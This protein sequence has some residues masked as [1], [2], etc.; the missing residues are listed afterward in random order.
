MAKETRKF[1]IGTL[2][3]IA[4]CGEQRRRVFKIELRVRAK[5]F[6]EFFVVAWE[7]GG[8]HD[9]VHF[10]ANAF[11]FAE[12]DLVN[13]L[14]S[15][16][17]CGVPFHVIQILR[18]AIRQRCRVSGFTALGQITRGQKVMQLLERRPD[19]LLVRSYGSVFQPDPAGIGER[20]GYLR[21]GLQHRTLYRVLEDLR[22]HLIRDISKR[23]LRRRHFRG[24]TLLHHRDRLVDKCRNALQ[25]EY[26]I[27][28]I[29]A[30]FGGHH[31]E[32]PRNILLNAFK[33]I[34]RHQQIMRNDTLDR[35]RIVVEFET[36]HGG[37]QKIAIQIIV[38]LLFRAQLRSID[39]L[40]P[41]QTFLQIIGPGADSGLRIVRPAHVLAG[42]S[43]GRREF[44]I[45][46]H[47]VSPILIELRAQCILRA[48]IRVR[49]LRRA[50]DCQQAGREQSKKK[51]MIHAANVYQIT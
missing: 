16:I 39:F 29:L 18:C 20:G 51:V 17:R 45:L 34:N 13:F 41:I 27:F 21:E 48:I 43:I 46:R 3:D 49:G 36:F 19:G 11:H 6:L 5:E 9:L 12:S 28:V 2:R 14:R 50:A 15:F 23:D 25:P 38:D 26:D 1:R 22:L 32:R 47:P 10:G 30:G 44:R 8:G 40:E 4:V 33:L 37:V 31:R 42:V 24:E 7:A 35:D